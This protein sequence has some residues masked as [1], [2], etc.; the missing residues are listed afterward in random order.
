MFFGLCL[1][2]PKKVHQNQPKKTPLEINK[3]KLK[4]LSKSTEKTNKNPSK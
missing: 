4:S 1:H 3:K 2:Q